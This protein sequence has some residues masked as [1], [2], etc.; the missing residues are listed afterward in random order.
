MRV[1]LGKLL[2]L[3][4][5]MKNVP[6]KGL[7]NTKGML[8]KQKKFFER[9]DRDAFEVVENLIKKKAI[10]TANG[11]SLLNDLSFINNVAKEL[12]A[13][14]NHLY[15]LSKNI[16]VDS[17]MHKDK[18]ESKQGKHKKHKGQHNGYEREL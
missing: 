13:A 1:D 16:S 8:K 5:Q 10:T 4:E 18:K 12:I 14:I 2:R 17:K 3:I 11:T 15:G 9:E 6:K 7:K